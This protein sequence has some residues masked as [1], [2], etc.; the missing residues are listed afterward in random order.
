MYVI[1]IDPGPV[2]GI[3]LLIG[4]PADIGGA[5]F[6]RL[7]GAEALQVTHGLTTYVLDG[8]LNVV[9]P[10]STVVAVERFVVGPRA[11]RSAHAGSGEVTRE[12]VGVIAH[13]AKRNQ[14]TC[15]ERSAAEVKPWATD[16]RLT[17]AGLLDVTKGMR[18]ARDA[19]RHALFCAV[20]DFG[21]ADPLSRRAG[22]L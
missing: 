6:P 3:A 21:L 16:D 8:L 10:Q 13:W 17:K 11:A 15:R 19:A 4:Q 7:L 1:G 5:W 9:V 18:H 20:R 2:A 12:L 22:A 14:L